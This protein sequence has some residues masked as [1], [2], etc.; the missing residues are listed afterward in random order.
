MA[1]NG[2][3]TFLTVAD[4]ILCKIDGAVPSSWPVML[5]RKFSS[6]ICEINSRVVLFINGVGS[7]AADD[8]LIVL[9]A[10]S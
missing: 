2:K 1:C 6:A 9:L 10:G 8:D 4:A 3:R 7:A 5:T